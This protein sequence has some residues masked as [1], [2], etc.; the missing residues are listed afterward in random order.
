VPSILLIMRLR[1]SSNQL[2]R[3]VQITPPLAR[4]ILSLYAAQQGPRLH[5]LPYPLLHVPPQLSLLH[6]VQPFVRPPSAVLP[7]PCR[8]LRHLGCAEAGRH[9]YT[10]ASDRS[11]HFVFCSSS[12]CEVPTSNVP[13]KPSEDNRIGP[14]VS[15][16]L[17]S[18]SLFS[19]QLFHFA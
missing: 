11:G 1:A 8:H 13:T 15:R 5:G 6:K 10:S 14:V 12:L 2:H 3:L 4:S 16:S 17:Y 9:C 7:L 19:A 18:S